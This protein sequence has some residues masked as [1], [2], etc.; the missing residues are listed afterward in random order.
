[1]GGNVVRN[2]ALGPGV[3]GLAAVGFGVLVLAASPA[4]AVAA[5]AM[6]PNIVFILGDDLGYGDLG[7]YGQRRIKTPNV[8]RLASEGTRF[9]Q[10]YAGSTVCA[11]S[12]C[13]LMTGLHSGH[14]RVRGNAL[15]PLRSDDVTVAEILKRAGYATGIVGKWG[16]GEPETSGLPNRKGFDFWFGYLNQHH[17][18]N[19]YPEFL[20]R[21]EQKYTL[22]GNQEKANIAI[23]AVQYAPDLFDREAL[24]FLDQH[25][26]GPFLL[27]LTSIL[28]HANNERGRAEGNGMEI[29]SDAPYT[30]ESWPQVE[31]NHAAMITR[32]D[33]EVGRILGKLKELGLED[34]TIVFFSSD[35]G[36]HKEGGADP[37][38]FG[39]AGPLRGYKRAL[40]DGGIRVP[41]IVRWP[42]KVP[43][44]AVSGAVWASWDILPTFSELAGAAAPSGIDGI[45]Q[46]GSL[47]GKTDAPRHDFLYWEFHEG[48]FKQAVRHGDWKAVR[49]AQGKPLELYNLKDDIGETHDIASE[50]ADVIARIEAYLKTARVDSPE[51]PIRT[52]SASR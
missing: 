48:G 50:H 5:E 31:K 39:S 8:D 2:A 27:F 26:T 32:L 14:G 18:H 44:G 40:Y 9:T 33:D 34:N 29:P 35:N 10:F 7:C 20:W 36:P 42:G 51:F 1:M 16:L 4:P 38:F 19:Y 11:P 45:S 43:A 37:K 52:S 3:I 30:G 24:S 23:K 41:M 25:T 6:R 15:V 47:L 49:T 22:E 21:N 28:P 12:R 17:A 46:V 13:A